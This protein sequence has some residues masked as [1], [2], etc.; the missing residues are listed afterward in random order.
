MIG[1]DSSPQVL[2]AA[3]IITFASLL[4]LAIVPF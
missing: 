4:L 1:P 3:F 2:A